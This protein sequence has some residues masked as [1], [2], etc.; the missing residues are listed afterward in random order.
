MEDEKKK[1]VPDE[2]TE[3]QKKEQ[4]Q[5]SAEETSGTQSETSEEATEKQG[6]ESAE[7]KA[8]EKADDMN[9]EQK[10]EFPPAQAE[11]D[12]PEKN[13]FSQELLLAKAELAAIKS[14]M[15]VSFAEDAVVLAVHDIRKEGGTPDSDS[16]EKAVKNVLKRHPEWNAKK[17][18][19]KSAG[20]KVGADGTKNRTTEDDDAIAR[21]FGNK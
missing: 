3:E 9:G 1:N 18:T 14:G 19:D 13:D 2:E 21:A 16:I 4:K 17:E 6:T 5:P 7:E 8:E 20:F 15:D 10:E 11:S 12:N